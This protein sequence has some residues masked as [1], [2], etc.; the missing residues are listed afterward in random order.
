M[1]QIV[2]RRC[3]TSVM[4][5][6]FTLTSLLALPFTLMLP[7]T[8][9]PTRY[10]YYGKVPERLWSY[11][12][13]TSG[14]WQLLNGPASFFLLAIG[15]IE[16]DTSI[17]V[18]DLKT[19]QR[20]FQYSF[21]EFEKQ[22]VILSNGTLFKV[23]SNKPVSMLLLNLQNPPNAT[24]GPV[25]HAFYPAVDGSYVGKHF[26]LLVSSDL[27]P[28][29]TIFALED[30]E[31]TVAREDGSDKQTFKLKA[32][33]YKRILLRS[34]YMYEVTSTGYIMVQCGDP[35]GYWDPHDSY[36][37]PSANGGFLGTD[38][39]SY[40]AMQ[41][42]PMEDVGFRVFAL[43]PTKVTVY[44]LE[45]KT[46]LMEFEMDAFNTH[47]FQATTQAVRVSSSKPVQVMLIHDGDT[48]KMAG[49]QANR[50]N[51]YGAGIVIYS[52]PAG[53]KSAAYLP[54]NSTGEIIIYA[55]EETILT[56]D[57][58]TT[59]KLKPDEFY[60]LTQPGLHSIFTDKNVIVQVNHWPKYPEFQGLWVS[61]TVIPAIET[62]GLV[63]EIEL[64]EI[65]GFAID[66]EL[67]AA[68]VA[69]LGAIAGLLLIRRRKS[70]A[71]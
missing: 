28:W 6:V 1:H 49:R 70:K 51:A 34:W 71:V 21:K 29:Y 25:P 38:F 60:V 69:I 67:I 56:I 30:S 4:I 61:G 7:A 15:A 26:V 20:V 54:V 35:H 41:W 55:S 57:E 65:A 12:Y 62:A 8:A 17:E 24:T 9:Q 53:R 46:V 23:S 64:K 42:D 40:S 22:Y 32:N 43:E 27:N 31:V 37:M 52:V 47:R 16:P 5:A 10:T 33:E 2:S 63:S 45:K 50:E 19:K 14:G 48:T 3:S 18:M 11:A 68:V 66:I 59:V 13:T 36:A 58:I 44:D 39:F